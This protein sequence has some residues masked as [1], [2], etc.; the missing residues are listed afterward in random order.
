VAKKQK[1]ITDLIADVRRKLS[2]DGVRIFEAPT[3]FSLAWWPRSPTAMEQF[4]HHIYSGCGLSG[5]K[6]LNKDF[7]AEVSAIQ[8]VL[9]KCSQATQTGD[10]LEDARNTV[11]ADT[12]RRARAM[13][14]WEQI[15]FPLRR[16]GDIVF[17]IRALR[18]IFGTPIIEALLTDDFIRGVSIQTAKD[19]GQIARLK[20]SLNLWKFIAAA[21]A[22][23]AILVSNELTLESCCTDFS[24]MRGPE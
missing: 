20:K 14:L 11:R 16:Y 6:D 1:T 4:V 23:A 17:R 9:K 3:L 13:S 12:N 18:D 7:F 19:K 5:V 21:S 15:A 24:F 10:A 2:D 8:D 22:A